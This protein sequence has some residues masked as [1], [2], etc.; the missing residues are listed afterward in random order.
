M[1]KKYDDLVDFNRRVTRERGAALRARFKILE[2]EEQALLDRKVDLDRKRSLK[3]R[4]LRS[5]DTFE[6]FKI[7]QKDLSEQRAQLVYLEEQRKRVQQVAE[8]ARKMRE[9]ERDRGRVV[10]EIK[11]LVEAETPIYRRF[12]SIFNSY[13]QRILNHDAV[14]YFR[15]NS[16]NNFDYEIG[17]SLPGK[18]GVASSLSDGTSYKKLICALFDLA[19]LKVYENAP[20]FHFVYHD[21]VMEG[22]D[23]RKKR[24]LLALIRETIGDR[25]IQYIMTLIKSDLPRDDEDQAIEFSDEE[26]VL[27]LHD[28]G[29]EGRLFKMAEF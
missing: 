27:R 6:K 5:T 7:L 11:A 19:L 10:D 13:C 16:N 23:N 22:L 3:L 18:T 15:V 28:E 12:Q 1:K 8:V 29:S 9:S 24:E 26:I 4:T 25:N 14:F 2:Q 21:G 20:F 17:L